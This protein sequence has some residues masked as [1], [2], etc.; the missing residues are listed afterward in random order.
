MAKK[1]RKSAY[2][3]IIKP[4][5]PI[6]SEMCRTHKEKQIAEEIGDFYAKFLK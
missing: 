5:F 3:T 6:I 1:G 4:N 2:E